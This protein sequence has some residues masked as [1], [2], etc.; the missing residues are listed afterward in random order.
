MIDKKFIYE[1]NRQLAIIVLLKRYL[2]EMHYDLSKIIREEH[3]KN[4]LNL[5]ER[6][7]LGNQTEQLFDRNSFKD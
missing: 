3:D 4:Q 5:F 7:N 1:L 2:H 6:N